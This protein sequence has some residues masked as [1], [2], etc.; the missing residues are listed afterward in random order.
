VTVPQ[1]ADEAGVIE[2]VRRDPRL[3]GTVFPDGGADARRTIFVPD[4][5]LNVVQASRG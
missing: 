2:A 1:G 4:K 3:G 5:L